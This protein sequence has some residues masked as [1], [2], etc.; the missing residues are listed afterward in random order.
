MLVNKR[1]VLIT[2][3]MFIDHDHSMAI[4]E[5]NPIQEHVMLAEK[6][7]LTMT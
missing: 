6:Y 7:R 5:K 3:E 2:K 4:A 1:Y